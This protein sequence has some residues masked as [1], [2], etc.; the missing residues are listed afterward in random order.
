MA[1]AAVAIAGIRAVYFCEL[2]VVFGSDLSK[3]WDSFFPFI[4]WALHV[5]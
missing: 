1:L 2:F 4:P 5:I 3:T